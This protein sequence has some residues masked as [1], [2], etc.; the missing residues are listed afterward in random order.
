MHY[1]IHYY[2]FVAQLQLTA[3][4]LFQSRAGL[5]QSRDDQSSTSEE[6]T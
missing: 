3:K 2:L 4:K 6:S 5:C 1:L